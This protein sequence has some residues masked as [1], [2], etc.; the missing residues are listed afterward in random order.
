[1]RHKY[2]I[3]LIILVCLFL[4]PLIYSKYSTVIN[5]T[6]T[7]NIRKPEYTVVFNPN[8]LP[9][10]YQEV[11][12]IEATGTQ[13]I[14][15]DVSMSGRLTLYSDG[16]MRAGTSGVLLN[17]YS[18]NKIKQGMKFI[19]SNNS[20]NSYWISGI[21]VT[22]SNLTSI[23]IDLTKRFQFTQDRTGVTLVQNG[24]VATSTYNGKT[25][26]VSR[27]YEI[28]LD[29]SGSNIPKYGVLYRAKILN[30]SVLLKD[31][32]PC[33]RK[34]DNVI[35]LFDLT[36]GT[37][38]TNSGTG[39]FVKGDDISESVYE[40]TKDKEKASHSLRISISHIT[41]KEEID[42]F[43]KKIEEKII[44]LQQLTK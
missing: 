9:S 8:V 16:F 37:F 11:E 36:N 31:F 34:S 20:Y 44:N 15:T 19:T 17:G 4:T 13:Y 10:A 33:Y 2:I 43:L 6:I 38:Y 3:I 28:F 5:K 18:N 24:L 42:Y 40:L 32:V 12:Y 22:N 21:N 29:G 26:K 25:N 27:P 30:G 1:M 14:V 41:T 39:T 35:G 7:V 23:G